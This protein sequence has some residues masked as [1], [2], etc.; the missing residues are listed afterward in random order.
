MNYTCNYTAKK[1]RA[2]MAL[3][4]AIWLSIT[5]LSLE[6]HFGVTLHRRAVS[7]HKKGLISIFRGRAFFPKHDYEEKKQLSSTKESRFSK[8][9]S[10]RAILALP[11]SQWSE[12]Q[13]FLNHPT[14]VTVKP[15]TLWI[16]LWIHCGGDKEP[17]C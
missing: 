10:K 7:E 6:L 14:H 9:L 4:G 15:K 5:Q 1:K 12:M 17:Q 8:L 3:L 11:F 2:K 16:R 13:N